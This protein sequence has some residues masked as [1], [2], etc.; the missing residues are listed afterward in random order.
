[1]KFFF[2]PLFVLAFALSGTTSLTA[3]C[4]YT[5]GT[6]G[7]MMFTG[8][9]PPGPGAT[10]IFPSNSNPPNGEPV[11]FD[12][13]RG[14][15]IELGQ[16]VNLTFD[17]GTLSDAS[18][19]FT[20]PSGGNNVSITGLGTFSAGAGSNPNGLAFYNTSLSMCQDVCTLG[21]PNVLPVELTYFSAEPT[22]KNVVLRWETASESENRHFIVERK[23]DVTDWAPLATVAGLGNSAAAVTYDFTDEQ[24]ASGLAYYRLRQED[25]DGSFSF[26]NVEVVRFTAS[27]TGIYPNPTSGK[28]T[29]EGDASAAI[30]N[31]AGKNVTAAAQTIGTDGVRVTFDVSSLPNGMYLLRTASGTKRFIKR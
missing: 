31:I 23:T 1:M 8:D 7:P 16:N 10:L 19:N 20:F 25:F 12:D 3:Q 26:S 29:F 18:T 14:V 6:S 5:A 17:G 30:F 2:T 4:T 28:I 11:P 13:L 21:D 24:P 9:C 15:I 27:S 22:R